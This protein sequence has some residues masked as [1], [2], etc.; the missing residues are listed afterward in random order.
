MQTTVIDVTPVSSRTSNE[1]PEPLVEGRASFALRRLK[2]RL[3]V[4]AFVLAVV[5]AVVIVVSIGLLIF[6]ALLG[7]A[8]A[9]TAVAMVRSA[10]GKSPGAGVQRRG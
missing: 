9:L 7:I 8:A 10:F 4:M 2:R 6:L 5:A 3:Q 1:P